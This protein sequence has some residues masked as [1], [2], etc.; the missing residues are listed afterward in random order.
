MGSYHRQRNSSSMHAC[1]VP[2]SS[3][4]IS[5]RPTGTH[6]HPLGLSWCQVA[7]EQVLLASGTLCLWTARID[8][9]GSRLEGHPC[10]HVKVVCTYNLH[11]SCASL[12]LLD[13]LHSLLVVCLLQLDR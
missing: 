4:E 5:S 10:M 7:V 3:H 12:T 11:C 9:V 13:F 8:G 6:R 1:C 2:C